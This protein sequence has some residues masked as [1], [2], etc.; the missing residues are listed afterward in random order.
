MAIFYVLF[1]IHTD[2]PEYSEILG[3]YKTKDKAVSELLER[4]NYRESKEGLL[5]QYMLPS[6]DYESFSVL[7]KKTMEKMEL[8]DEDIYRITECF[9]K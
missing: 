2:N 1:Y 9:C 7:Y 5:T 3:I 4:A 6:N 8:Y